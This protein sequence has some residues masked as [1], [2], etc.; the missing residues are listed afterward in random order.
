LY[1]RNEESKNGDNEGYKGKQKQ[2]LSEKKQR[3]QVV[4]F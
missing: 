4:M 3:K 1:D 2:A